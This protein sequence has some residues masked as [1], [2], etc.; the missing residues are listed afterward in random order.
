MLLT[1][2]TINIVGFSTEYSD[3]STLEIKSSIITKCRT[4]YLSYFEQK[5]HIT[6]TQHIIE[7]KIR[8]VT[9]VSCSATGYHLRGKQIACNN[10]ISPCNDEKAFKESASEIQVLI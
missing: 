10:T 2:E 6:L 1:A 7:T 4:Y 8:K 9:M 3:E 5:E